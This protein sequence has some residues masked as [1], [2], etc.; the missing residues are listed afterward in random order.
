MSGIH[1]QIEKL[2]INTPIRVMFIA[3]IYLT[4]LYGTK[5]LNIF[6]VS[7]SYL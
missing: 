1:L 4:M 2:N 6:A 7:F 5:F 3:K